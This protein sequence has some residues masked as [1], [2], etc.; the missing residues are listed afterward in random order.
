MHIGVARIR[1]RGGAEPGVQGAEP[2]VMGGLRG[3]QPPQA[4]RFCDFDVKKYVVKNAM[5][6]HKRF[7]LFFSF[8][9]CLYIVSSFIVPYGTFNL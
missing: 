8:L 2:P 1:A 7:L 3:Q 9:S 6:W 4:E 5:N